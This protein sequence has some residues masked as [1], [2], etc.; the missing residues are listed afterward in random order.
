MINEPE[1]EVGVLDA[2][3][4]FTPKNSTHSAIATVRANDLVSGPG[5]VKLAQKS[6]ITGAVE[7]LE[8]PA[9]PLT[10]PSLRVS[11][12]NGQQTILRRAGR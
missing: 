11:G 3:G 2:Q 9:Q 5:Y 8:M 4:N 10:T 6:R 12:A 7:V 1:P